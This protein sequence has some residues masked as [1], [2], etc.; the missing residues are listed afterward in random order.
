MFGIALQVSINKFSLR[1]LIIRI[2]VFVGQRVLSAD[3]LVCIRGANLASLELE[4]GISCSALPLNDRFH[5]SLPSGHLFKCRA[6]LIKKFKSSVVVVQ[7][8]VVRILEQSVTYTVR[9]PSSGLLSKSFGSMMMLMY[10]K[11]SSTGN[12]SSAF[13]WF[14]RVGL[15][16]GVQMIFSSS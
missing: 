6:K 14:R 4:V 3:V 9:T 16:A 13:S 10:Q 12:I 5:F 2:F 11:F 7:S 8:A 1:T 15:P